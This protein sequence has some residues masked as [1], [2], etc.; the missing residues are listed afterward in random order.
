[1][2]RKTT[3]KSTRTVS[4]KKTNTGE[5]VKQVGRSESA[6]PHVPQR[7]KMKG[8]L[9]FNKQYDFSEKQCSVIASIMDK[10]TKVVFLSGPAGAAKAQ[11]LSST[12]Y[13]PDG[14]TTMGKLSVGSKVFDKNGNSTEVL[15]IFPQGKKEVYK[16]S[17]SDGT[18][19][20]CCGDHLWATKNEYERNYYIKKNGKKYKTE[21]PFTVRTTDQLK[22]NI[23]VRDG[24]LNYSIPMCD[25]VKFSKK[26]IKIDPYILGCLLGDGSLTIAVRISSEDSEIINTFKEKLPD[27]SFRFDGKCGYHISY[28]HATNNPLLD[29]IRR[30]GLNSRSEYKFIP[31]NYKYSSVEDRIELLQGLMDTDG[32]ISSRSRSI[33]FSNTSERLIDDMVE[34]VN[35]LGGIAKKNKRKAGYKKNGEYIECLDCYTLSINLPNYILPFKLSRKLDKIIPKTKYFP[36]RY[37]TNIELIGEKDCQCILVDNEEHLYLTDNFIVTHNTYLA[38]LGAL[39]SIDQ[40]KASHLIYVRSLAESASKSIGAL[41]GELHEKYE[42]FLLP[43]DDKINEIITKSSKEIL[44]KEG[45]IE[46]IPINFLR[47]ASINSACVLIDEAQNLTMKELTTAIT[48]IG[49][50]SKFIFLGDP[51]Q[52]DI[53]GKSGFYRMYN[54]FNN[55]ESRN[56][57]IFCHEFNK[58]DIVRSGVLR[59]IAEKIETDQAAQT[60]S[61]GNHQNGRNKEPMFPDSLSGRS[62]YH[63]NE[64]NKNSVSSSE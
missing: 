44:K 55:E 9:I 35:S 50:D 45:R 1:M 16:I 14:P 47:G 53:N 62:I 21:I 46:A 29:E 5:N 48:R 17:F 34:L 63:Y 31:N 23:I 37:I 38:V 30:L 25:P 22:E 51:S 64:P 7:G 11:P 27:Y 40:K 10:D 57:G 18:S 36:I 61:N 19:T 12:V 20:E 28:P 49:E 39:K 4:S 41:P 26:D 54:I 43:L 59:F 6:T 33:S 52:S 42:P 58:D 13:T 15:A 32:T 60:K 24:R 56:N 3:R 8:R 2:S